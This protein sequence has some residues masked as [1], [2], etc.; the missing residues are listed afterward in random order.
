MCVRYQ[1]QNGEI[2]DAP[3]DC[4]CIMHD[5]PHWLY[6]DAWWKAQNRALLEA[7][8]WFAFAGEELVRLRE[9]EVEMRVR[10]IGAVL[11]DDAPQHWD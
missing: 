7:G 5:G 1:L 8:N 9:K 11:S 2:V 4:E 10:Y 3:K 6:M